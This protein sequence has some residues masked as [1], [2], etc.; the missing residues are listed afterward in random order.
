M[1]LRVFFFSFFH[2]FGAA[3]MAYESFQARGQIGTAAETYAAATATLDPSCI[4]DLR[5]SL[6]QC[7]ILNSLIEA[8]DG[9]LTLTDTMSGP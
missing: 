5:C 2:L 8:R 1:F 9:T 3:S 4:F 7:W 6:W